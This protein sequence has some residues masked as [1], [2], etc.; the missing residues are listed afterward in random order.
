MIKFLAIVLLVL[1]LAACNDGFSE[2]DWRYLPGAGGAGGSGGSVPAPAPAQPA[3]GYSNGQPLA[4]GADRMPM[5]QD[6]EGNLQDNGI[7]VKANSQQE[8][9]NLCQDIA[10]SQSDPWTIVKCLGCRL[11]TMTTGK[12]ICTLRT[13]IVTPP[14]EQQP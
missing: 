10:A 5:L 9:E 4:P 11:R 13:E 8:A 6:P 1:P 3:P 7:E 2:M 14:T 12:Y